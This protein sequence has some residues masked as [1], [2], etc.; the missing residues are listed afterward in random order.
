MDAELAAEMDAHRAEMHDPSRFGN[1]LRL[2][3]ASHDE[4]GWTWLDDAVRDVRLAARALRRTPG[5]T[6][7][8]VASLVLGLT[9]AACA[10]AVTNAYL[11][12]SLPYPSSSRLYHV[13]Y[14]PPGPYEPGGLSAL[15]WRSVS[16]VVEMP[17]TTTSETLY[18]TEGRYAQPSRALR[19]NRGFLDA[20]GVRAV[21]GRSFTDDEL[22]QDGGDAV[23]IGHALWR[24]RFARDSAVI[25]RTFRAD[26]G[27]Q[28]GERRTYRI[29][30]VLTPGFWFGRESS[31]LVDVVMPLRS[32]ARTYLVRL[33]DGVPASLAERRLTDATRAVAT[34]LPADW[35]GVHLVSAHERYVGALRPVLLGVTVA[36]ALV[37]V[38][39]CVNVSVLVLLRALHRQKEMSV[40]VALGA[41]RRHIVRLLM[42]ESGLLCVVALLLVLGLT[43]TALRL[44]APLIE[45]QLGR[46]APGGVSA[47]TLDGTVVLAVAI[48]GVVIAFSLCLIPLTTPW[49]RRLAQTLHG[50]GRHGTDG[51][52]MARV[53]SVLIGF[54]LAGS[55][56]LLV[57]CGLMLRSVLEMAQA[58]LGFRTDDVVRVR[59][60]IP[61]QAYAD[62]STR[63][64]FYDRVTERAAAL[65]R[66]RVALTS[67][68]PF[69]ESMSMP[70]VADGSAD[71]KPTGGIITVGPDYFTVLGTSIRD[72]RAF[73][74]ADRLGAEPVAIVSETLARRLWPGQRAVGHRIRAVEGAGRSQP[75]A[76]W[77]T[78]VGVA[79]DVRQTYG[80][81]ELGDVYL[82]FYQIPPERF[83]TFYLQTAMSA[84][85]VESQ[86]RSAIAE[87]DPMAI[88][89]GAGSVESENR[90]LAGTRFLT[91]MLSAFGALAAIL[92][93]VGMYGA[94]AY[95]VLQRR[96]EFAIRIALGATRQAVTRLS[97]R[98]GGLVVACGLAAGV[99]A[100]SG[101]G[102]VLRSRLYG[103]PAFD[104][105]TILAAC[106][107]MG[108]AGLVAVWW[109][110]RRAASV[111]PVTILSDS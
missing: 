80:D 5:F 81:P 53:R 16:D 41:G 52:S 44:L 17:V 88:V 100:A 21:L 59:V 98:T 108:G 79:Q 111:D 37:L 3:E 77:R 18:L 61:E 87:S 22:A 85:A 34:D 73:T 94:I 9:L 15:D 74:R 99:L 4:W 31:A 95:A 13:M 45:S 42:A 90:Q 86:L 70:L 89:R 29:V 38:I 71:L 57:G 69:A 19:V 76:T 26:V 6:V 106:V 105:W 30:G 64:A 55:L 101:A 82:P 40:R 51:T 23:M 66:A 107:L 39:A 62:A 84:V 32:P 67:W 54:E 47:I 33:R 49:R 28:G 24:D 1:T 11:I 48:T 2:R 27:E 103:V 93:V 43:R 35:T 50:A 56:V 58:D 36:A 60:V 10:V 72:G 68:P 46:P 109:P 75:V 25:G 7:V 96:R 8:T 20:L 102:R 12:R 91:L 14:A 65:A 78:V 104:V 92:A 63:Y 97:M 110:A 83:G